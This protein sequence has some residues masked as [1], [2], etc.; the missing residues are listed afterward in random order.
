LANN[1][2]IVSLLAN[3]TVVVDTSVATISFND[4]TGTEDNVACTVV[5]VAGVVVVDGDGVVVVVGGVVVVVGGVVVGGVIVDGIAVV[6][7]GVIS[8][9]A[10]VVIRVC[11]IGRFG[12]DVDCVD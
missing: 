10:N 8:V 5:V 12:I 2:P 3:V 11:E 1:T 4:C 9:F 6:V 7:D